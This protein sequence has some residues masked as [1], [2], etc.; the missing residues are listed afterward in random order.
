MK[1]NIAF[2]LFLKKLEINNKIE[3]IWLGAM[4]LVQIKCYLYP[5]EAQASSDPQSAE[6]RR[7]DLNSATS[8]GVFK[9]LIKQVQSAYKGLIPDKNSIRLYWLDNENEHIG[10]SNDAET[11]YAINFQ[12]KIMQKKR[13]MCFTKMSP[14]LPSLKIYVLA[15]SSVSTLPKNTT[16]DTLPRSKGKVR[17]KIEKMCHYSKKTIRS[18]D[19]KALIPRFKSADR[20]GNDQNEPLERSVSDIDLT[21]GELQSTSSKSLKKIPKELDIFT[22][23]VEIVDSRPRRKII[24]LDEDPE[25]VERIN[26]F[27]LMNISLS[28]LE[29]SKPETAP[30]RKPKRTKKK[31]PLTV[32]EKLL[33]D[34]NS[35]DNSPLSKEEKEE[36]IL[37][38]NVKFYINH[39]VNTICEEYKELE[40]PRK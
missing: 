22:D 8:Q 26:E 40:V 39:L 24:D 34:I 37:Q 36:E 7:F 6:I 12:K 4:D 19:F 2:F 27:N 29:A 28:D 1:K 20:R 3:R 18:K 35:V 23:N 32:E 25:Y 33:R 17:Q 30:V 9:Q 16:A 14:D 10:C 21:K 38:L 15:G 11:E 13:K 5:S 31:K